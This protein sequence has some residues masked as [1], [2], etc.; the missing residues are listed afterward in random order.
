MERN[1]PLCFEQQGGSFEQA[2]AFAL[3]ASDANGA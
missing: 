3:I 2:V 1:L